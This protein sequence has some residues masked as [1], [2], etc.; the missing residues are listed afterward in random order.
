[1]CFAAT[2]TEILS[3]DQ[4][5]ISTPLPST[6][7]PSRAANAGVRVDGQAHPEY[8]GEHGS[9]WTTWGE[10][11]GTCNMI[12]TQSAALPPE[13]ITL[14]NASFGGAFSSI[15]SITNAM[16]SVDIENCELTAHETP[17]SLFTYNGSRAAG[18]EV[19]LHIADSEIHDAAYA[20]AGRNPAYW[21]PVLG[22]GGY[23]HPNVNVRCVRT[24]FRDSQGTAIKNFSADEIK[25]TAG[26]ME[27]T[28]CQM[29]RNA[30]GFDGG[31]VRPRY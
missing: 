18:A 6:V 4:A 19:H 28:D 2:I 3:A 7:D 31:T 13:L 23:I 24:I 30:E 29:L 21:S 22:H 11:V 14:H 12:G 17:V 20:P 9:F 1:M 27:Y 26:C 8:L 10:S 5:R 16:A 15:V 25:E